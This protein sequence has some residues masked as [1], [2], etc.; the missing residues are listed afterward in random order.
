MWRREAGEKSCCRWSPPFY[1]WLPMWFALLLLCQLDW[2]DVAVYASIITPS[3]CTTIEMRSNVNLTLF[4]LPLSCLSS[5]PSWSWQSP[6]PVLHLSSWLLRRPWK[7][8]INQTN[9]HAFPCC[10][11]FEVLCQ[12]IDWVTTQ[13]YMLQPDKPW[14]TSLWRSPKTS[15][16][17][18]IADHMNS[19]ILTQTFE[20]NSNKSAYFQIQAELFVQEK[21]MLGLD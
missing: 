11:R 10:A 19:L 3:A 6:S 9:N 20:D 16:A 13:L 18:P 1:L 4:F 17:Q 8:T 15:R 5:I 21:K 14:Q 7:A 2:L 12:T